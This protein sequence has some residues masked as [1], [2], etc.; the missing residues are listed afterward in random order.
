M[1][2]SKYVLS[3]LTPHVMRG[4]DKERIRADRAARRNLEREADKEKRRQQRQ[5]EAEQRE[6]Q[7]KVD[8]DDPL[9]GGSSARAAAP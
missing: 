8:K 1:W 9:N 4:Y 2:P 3:V 5:L 7:R 6:E